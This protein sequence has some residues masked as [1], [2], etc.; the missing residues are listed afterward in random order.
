M[1]SI[2][3]PVYIACILAWA[4]TAASA[5]LHFNLLLLTLI[6]IFSG[7]SIAGVNLSLNNIGI[8]LAPK[9]SAMAY[10]SAKNMII[11]CASAGAPL[12]GGLLADF[13]SAEWNVLFL[14]GAMLAVLSM[15]MLKNI[16]EAGEEKKEI[17]FREMLR[18]LKI[19]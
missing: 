13:F 7:S 12:I 17:V 3:A 4:F 1:I 8:K 9:G 16:H 10:L 19:S 5:S 2:C 11:A 14:M 18:A 15:R 6:N